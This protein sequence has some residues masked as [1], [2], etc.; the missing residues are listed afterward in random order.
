MFEYE[1]YRRESVD[2]ACFYRQGT[3]KANTIDDAVKQALAKKRK[4]WEGEVVV[5]VNV[6]TRFAPHNGLA[7]VS[8]TTP[9]P[10]PEIILTRV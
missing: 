9:A 6:T 1:V 2:A 7:L 5:V 3:F 8:I 4:S 10:Q